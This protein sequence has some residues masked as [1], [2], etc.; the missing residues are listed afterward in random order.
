MISKKL[1]IIS[2]KKFNRFY[3]LIVFL[4][5]ASILELFGL[6][7]IPLFLEFILDPE[8]SVAAKYFGQNFSN[9]FKFDIYHFCALVCLIYLL[10]NVFL[11]WVYFFEQN[12]VYLLKVQNA[13][14]LFNYYLYSPINFYKKKKFS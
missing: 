13:Q 8:K 4:F 11:S 3:Y 10:K 7:S 2:G 5:L 9:K 14:K 1:K 6:A 12:I